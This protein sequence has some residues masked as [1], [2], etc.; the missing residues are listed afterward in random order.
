[1]SSNPD[2]YGMDSEKRHGQN[3]HYETRE[4]KIAANPPATQIPISGNNGFF[5]HGGSSEDKSQDQDVPCALKSGGEGRTNT[6]SSQTLH[7][8]SHHPVTRSN[9]KKMGE[10]AAHDHGRQP[11]FTATL[12]ETEVPNLAGTDHQTLK[13]SGF[14]NCFSPRPDLNQKFHPDP[15]SGT[16]NNYPSSETKQQQIYND[17]SV[18]AVSDSRNLMESSTSQ[19]AN[20]YPKPLITPDRHQLQDYR[21]RQV[22]PQH[23]SHKPVIRSIEVHN[24]FAPKF[25]PDMHQRHRKEHPIHPFRPHAPHHVPPTEVQIQLQQQALQ[26]VHFRSLQLNASHKQTQQQMPN[27]LRNGNQILPSDPCETLPQLSH[28]EGTQQMGPASTSTKDVCDV[29]HF[30]HNSKILDQKGNQFNIKEVVNFLRQGT[31]YK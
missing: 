17:Y 26:D 4:K 23:I 14:Q 8:E 22:H 27:V 9:A 16:V 10:T 19:E 2:N 28:P 29:H 25:P 24:S 1:M 21:F 5:S 3:K 18:G 7:L 20:G 31:T 12:K 15:T 13:D 30:Q 6:A 11:H